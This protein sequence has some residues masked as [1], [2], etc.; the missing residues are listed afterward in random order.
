MAEFVKS[1]YWADKENIQLFIFRKQLAEETVD[2]SPRPILFLVHGSSFAGV[3]GHDLEVPGDED[4][5]AM[6]AFARLGYDVWSMDH[7]GYGFSGLREGENSNIAS[8]VVDLELASEIMAK[9]TGVTAYAFSGQSSGA[10]RAAAFAEAHP[11]R[12]TKLILGAMVWTGEGSPTLKERA[13]KLD[14]W[15]SNNKRPVDQAFFE[16]IFSRDVEGLADQEVAKAMAVSESRFAGFVPTGTYLDM[17]ANLPVCDP[18]KI[19]CPVM[20]VRGEHDG[21]ASPEDL[22]A[23]YEK[24]PN[25]DKIFITMAGQAHATLLGYNRHRAIHLFHN[26]LSLP[27]RR[28]PLYQKENR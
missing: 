26:F 5:S 18:E 12:V 10:L 13:K 4:Y 7:E 1:E 14:Q 22:I 20:I 6:N 8:G 17:C 16:T 24:L 23:F 21:I 3:T 11:E 28:D 15:R 2:G 9:E 27:E 19:G 25:K